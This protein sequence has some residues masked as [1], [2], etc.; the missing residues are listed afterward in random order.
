MRIIQLL[1]TVGHNIKQDTRGF[2]LI[3]G[4]ISLLLIAVGT[5]AAITG[6][7]EYNAYQERQDALQ[8]KVSAEDKSALR[9]YLTRM[10]R[11][12]PASNYCFSRVASLGNLA[13]YLSAFDKIPVVQMPGDPLGV[14]A[15]Y[16]NGVIYLADS[17]SNL[18]KANQRLLEI[19]IWHEVTHIIEIDNGDRR[20]LR[21]F[22]DENKWVMRGERHTEY[23]EMTE[24]IMFSLAELEDSVRN[25]KVDKAR[26]R[27]LW[28]R[29]QQQVASGSVNTFESI[30]SDL[31]EFS[32][33]TGFKFTFSDIESM[34]KAGSCIKIPDGIL[35][36]EPEPEDETSEDVPLL[37]PGLENSTG[38]PYIIWE[39]VNANVGLNITKRTTFEAKSLAR[40]Y[41]GGGVDPEKILEKKQIISQEFPSY[42]AAETFICA[43][44]T[45][46][47]AGATFLGS[48]GT[49]QGETHIIGNFDCA[50]NDDYYNY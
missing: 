8:Y 39:G 9:D 5:P 6:V 40:D 46:I 24:G 21:V 17:V 33:Y 4:I 47:H 44:I 42:D 30:P 45:N 19:T 34:Y 10:V 28:R 27:G 15:R 23:M 41:S 38:N 36:D 50:P 49:Y 25:K 18:A 35:E 16:E 22:G 29:A 20:S 7:S 1:H 26:L 12:Y 13:T 14:P 2:T 11:R 3:S 48:V 31:A 43:D 37:D 32:S